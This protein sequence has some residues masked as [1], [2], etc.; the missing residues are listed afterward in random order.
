VP[1]GAELTKALE[2]AR[3]VHL[4]QGEAGETPASTN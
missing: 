1:P 4:E 2:S 3:S